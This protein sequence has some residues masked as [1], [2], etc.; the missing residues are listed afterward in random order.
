MVIYLA[1]QLDLVKTIKLKQTFKNIIIGLSVIIIG[2]LLIHSYN[3]TVRN[4]KLFEEN[5][6]LITKNSIIEFK[7]DSIDKAYNI[8]FIEN[9]K[10]D[11]TIVVLNEQFKKY[12]LENVHLQSKLTQLENYI[13][14]LSPDTSYK[15]IDNRYPSK[16]FRPY[17]FSSSQVKSIHYDLLKGDLLKDLNY[18]LS[19]ELLLSESMYSIRTQMYDN[20]VVQ[21]NL[22]KYKVNLISAQNNNLNKIVGN[23]DKQIKLIK[24]GF[25]SMTGAVG[26]L[27]TYAIIKGIIK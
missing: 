2:G 6:S 11:S 26:I 5:A 10:K 18:T 7:K 27:A 8:I 17:R 19:N 9:S 1:K 13:A 12:K 23:K 3:L 22:L 24:F 4:S 16:D 21:N 15:Y 20:S 25:Y 14:N